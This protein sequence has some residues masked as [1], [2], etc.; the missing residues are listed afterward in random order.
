MTALRAWERLRHEAAIQSVAIDSRRA[1]PA[2]LW[3]ATSLLGEAL[4]YELSGDYASA[5]PI[6]TQLIQEF[7]DSPAAAQAATR[8]DDLGLP[9]ITLTLID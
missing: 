9:L 1:V 7:S 5:R 8:V 3:L 2:R 4:A 6:L